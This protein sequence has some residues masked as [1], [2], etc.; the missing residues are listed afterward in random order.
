VLAR[1]T[2][3]LNAHATDMVDAGTIGAE[4]DAIA[5]VFTK[6]S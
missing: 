2:G 6:E 3:V 1:W 5:E 4:A